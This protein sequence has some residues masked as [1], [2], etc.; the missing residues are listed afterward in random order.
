[1]LHVIQVTVTSAGSVRYADVLAR[2]RREYADE[3]RVDPHSTLERLP[4]AEDL[5]LAFR[6]ADIGLVAQAASRGVVGYGKVSSWVE[7]DGTEVHLLDAWAAPGPCQTAAATELFTKLE[8]WV[9]DRVRPTA[10]TVLGANCRSTEPGRIDLLTRLG[11]HW[12]FDM[13]EMQ[14][15]PGQLGS[16]PLP[17]HV[18]LR[19]VAADDASAIAALTER[20]WA[21]RPFFSTSSLEEVRQELARADPELYLLAEHESHLIG[22]ASAAIAVGCAE[23]DDVQVDSTWQR[24]GV[25]TALVSELVSRLTGRTNQPVRLHTEGHDPAGARSRYEQLGFVVVSTHHRYRKQ[26]G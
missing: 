14:F 18:V 19:T 11:F 8:A 7:D 3:D 9:R 22:L 10:R 25:A 15:T 12:V 21:N 5:R 13:V 16:R 4:T 23:I 26:L 2:L 1:M 17:P 20:V 6:D 24:H